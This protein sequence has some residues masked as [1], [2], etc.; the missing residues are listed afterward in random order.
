M[1]NIDG[2]GNEGGKKSNRDVKQTTTL[3]VH[4]TFRVYF[5]A[6]HDYDVKLPSFTFYVERKIKTT[7]FIFFFLTLNRPLEFNARK[8][9]Q[10]LKI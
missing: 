4:H 10:H 6:L 8:I 2:K 1:S 9:R 5:F 3:L 7:I